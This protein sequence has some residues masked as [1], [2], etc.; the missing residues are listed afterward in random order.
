MGESGIDEEMLQ[1]NRVIKTNANVLVTCKSISPVAI[2]TLAEN[3]V[4]SLILLLFFQ[5]LINLVLDN[6]IV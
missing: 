5:D 2:Q 3:N 6:G 1:A 4:L